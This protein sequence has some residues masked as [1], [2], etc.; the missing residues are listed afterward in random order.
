MT[1][2]QHQITEVR[3]Q[4]ARGLPTD[5][6]GWTTVKNL[7]PIQSVRGCG[8]LV[9]SARV[10]AWWGS[11]SD[12][13][14]RLPEGPVLLPNPCPPIGSFLRIVAVSRTITGA[15]VLTERWC[16]FIDTIQPDADAQEA[17]I[18][19]LGLSAL[20]AKVYLARGWE[21]A[22][23][24]STVVDPGYCPPFN[25]LAGGDRSDQDPDG[26]T[27]VHDRANNT[28]VNWWAS[29]IANL[30]LV[31]ATWGGLAGMTERLTWRLG[32][33]PNAVDYQPATLDPDGRTVADL[34]NELFNPR[35]GTTWRT[36]VDAGTIYV[37]VIRLSSVVALNVDLTG[38]VMVEK[39]TVVEEAAPYDLVMV[40]SARP[41]VGLT[42]AWNPDSPSASAILP[43]GWNPGVD[44]DAE[45]DN[46]DETKPYDK[47]SWRTF[48]MNPEWDGVTYGK[49][50][51]GL[52]SRITE[53]GS[54]YYDTP[55]PS[56]LA[57]E[58]ERT[59]PWGE[60][61]TTD[62]TG[63]RQDPIVIAGLPAAYAD[64]TK[65]LP[66]ITYGGVT[67]GGTTSRY[68]GLSLGS[69]SEDAALLR[70]SLAG[71]GVLLVT[72][73]A[74][75]WCPLKTWAMTDPSAWPVP[76]VPRIYR[77]VLSGAE[78][79]RGCNGAITGVDD[80]GNLV[81][82]TTES[83]IRDDIA[84]LTQLRDRLAD[85]FLYPHYRARWKSRA[86]LGSAFQ[87]GDYVTTLTTASG[88]TY[89]V[90]API[91]QITEDYPAATQGVTYEC[92]PIRPDIDSLA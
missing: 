70:D 15:E 59:T 64:L 18:H 22:G 49:M 38:D 86:G 45:V 50:F 2:D 42:L 81:T 53:D 89:P 76:G 39:P 16:G 75:E 84:K 56:S 31:R 11:W 6:A 82:A 78:Q 43:D 60:G 80:A 71:G 4:V 27:Y 47:P 68:A 9:G 88:V 23:D 85:W 25:A 61:F 90:N 28:R 29:D 87:P 40:T 20:L 12:P 72:L 44:A 55:S 62:A 10:N 24:G 65:Q 21:L 63:K 73:A 19:A 30:L 32:D 37:D 77:R 41:L 74:R 33:F 3:A 79:W 69:T 14:D 67:P 35:Y 36:R 34:L 7:V 5:A 46:H 58:L 66:L 17:D 48:R 91:T 13:I 92:V 52:N 83:M 51:D 26:L 57:L 8:Q 1:I 54:R